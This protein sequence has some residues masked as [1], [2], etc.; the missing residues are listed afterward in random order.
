MLSQ[1]QCN[2]VLFPV[3]GCLHIRGMLSKRQCNWVLQDQTHKVS[4]AFLCR[5]QPEC[6]LGQKRLAMRTWKQFL[7]MLSVKLEQ[8]FLRNGN[9][10][11][12]W[13]RHMKTNEQRC[14]L[15]DKPFCTSVG[16][17]SI[18]PCHKNGVGT[19]CT[20]GSLCCC[21]FFWEEM[22][23]NLYPSCNKHHQK[24]YASAIGWFPSLEKVERKFP[25]KSGTNYL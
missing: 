8:P 24:L 15:Q 3:C 4:V 14:Y 17:C 6:K 2:W 23:L 11:I 18:F 25:G 12:P 9:T 19:Y 7:L 22:Q 16:T 5:N 21:I 1:R 20:L 10:C 13:V